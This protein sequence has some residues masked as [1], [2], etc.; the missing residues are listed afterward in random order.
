MFMVNDRF[1]FK[2]NQ[3]C[4]LKISMR[5]LLIKKGHGGSLVGHFGIP[6]TL[7]IHQHFYWP[8]MLTSVWWYVMQCST[9][10]REKMTFL[11]NMQ[12]WIM[13]WLYPYSKK[14]GIYHVDCR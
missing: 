1:Y 11:I 14:K 13:W 5:Q 6:K 9:C 3:L 12:A 4:V 10:Q 8:H 2:C 7:E